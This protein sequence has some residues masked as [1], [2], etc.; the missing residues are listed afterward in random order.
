MP[1]K[2]DDDL[3][4]LNVGVQLHLMRRINDWRKHRAD[5]NDV[6]SVSEAVRRLLEA[7]LEHEASAAP[8]RRRA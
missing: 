8:K 3:K 1:P 4:R 6:P 2:L 5:D 7:G